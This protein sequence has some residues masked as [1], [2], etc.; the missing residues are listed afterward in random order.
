MFLKCF[1]GFCS[2]AVP[3]LAVSPVPLSVSVGGS[4]GIGRAAVSGFFVNFEN[5]TSPR[6]HDR[7]SVAMR[8]VRLE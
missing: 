2:S 7:V 1:F 8:N 5:K 3:S 4:G 6:C